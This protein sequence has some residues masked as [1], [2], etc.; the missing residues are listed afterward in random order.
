MASVTFTADL[1][2]RASDSLGAGRP[3]IGKTI[4]WDVPTRAFVPIS[5]IKE[6]VAE[7]GLTSYEVSTPAIREGQVLQRALRN[8]GEAGLVEEVVTRG[9][10]VVYQLTARVRD[11][12][13]DKL[14]YE[15]RIKIAHYK[16]G[17]P[18][19]MRHLQNGPDPIIVMSQDGQ[20]VDA[21]TDSE[22]RNLVN[23]FR[24]VYTPRDITSHILVEACQTH[25]A[26]KLRRGGG[27]Q[28]VPADDSGQTPV[29]DKLRAFMRALGEEINESCTLYVQAAY[30]GDDEADSIGQAALVAMMSELDGVESDIS[31]RE[32]RVDVVQSAT[33]QAKADRVDEI[34]A[35]IA[36]YC[37]IS[38]LQSQTLEERAEALRKRAFAL[39]QAADARPETPKRG[40]RKVAA[41]PVV[42]LPLAPARRTARKA[43]SEADLAAAAGEV[44][45]A[46]SAGTRR[47]ARAGL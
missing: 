4:I 19:N 26:I 5:R 25:G 20:P 11:R 10:R 34:M 14:G 33:A 31:Q 21:I 40:A 32:A 30:Q 45:E 23:R 17:V 41:A 24:N 22:V 9:D 43:I 36:R 15:Q 7:C 8:L 6:L 12:E 46:A 47:K 18:D 44:A 28:F 29:V 16:A 35:K 1:L 39:K 38:N 37:A 42:E 3:L 13:R 2:E 27:A